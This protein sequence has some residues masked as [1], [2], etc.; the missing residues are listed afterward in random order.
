MV[1]EKKCNQPFYV[2][3]T[4]SFKMNKFLATLL[5]SALALSFGASAIAADAAKPAE[6]VKAAVV[7]PVK[8]DAAKVADSAKTEATIT[9]PATDAKVA[10][11]KK[12]VKKAKKEATKEVAAAVTVVPAVEAAPVA[13]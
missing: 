13:K 9:A 4:R 1:T 5:A 3:L 7:E 11:V 2:L 10:P 8:A 12:S 6:A